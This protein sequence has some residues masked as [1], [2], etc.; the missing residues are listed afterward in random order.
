M[1]DKR[2]R[3]ENVI[4]GLNRVVT[5]RAING[6][7]GKERVEFGSSGKNIMDELPKEKFM[8]VVKLGFP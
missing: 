5:E 2:T 8:S 6:R 3:D 1:S 7:D 4:R